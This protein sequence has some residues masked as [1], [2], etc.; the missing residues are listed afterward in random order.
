MTDPHGHHLRHARVTLDGHRTRFTD[1]NG[2]VSFT[3]VPK[4]R[5]AIRITAADEPTLTADVSLN[6]GASQLT[7]QLGGT[8]FSMTPWLW[9]LLVVAAALAT[10]AAAAGWRVLRRRRKTG[11]HGGP[12][13]PPQYY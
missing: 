5:H 10:A 9:A 6:P 8:G 3:A 4:G 13:G 2:R 7:Y 11:R 12:V 1:A